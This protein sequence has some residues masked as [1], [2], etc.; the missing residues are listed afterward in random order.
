MAEIKALAFMPT[1][2]FIY[3]D[4]EIQKTHSL[5]F[6]AKPK[7]L[8]IQSVSQSWRSQSVVG[9]HLM[10]VGR[11]LNPQ[12]HHTF[13]YSPTGEVMLNSNELNLAICYIFWGEK[14]F[15]LS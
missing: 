14:L 9:V 5:Q 1:N 3:P 10:P 6:C 8:G 11:L 13:D 2:A 12:T 7:N 15:T 4:S